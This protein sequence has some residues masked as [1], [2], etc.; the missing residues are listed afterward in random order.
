MMEPEDYLRYERHMKALGKAAGD[1]PRAFADAV[2]LQEILDMQIRAAIP[3][4]LKQGFSWG[5][6]AN[7]LGIT[8]QVAHRKYRR[9]AG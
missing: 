5:D 1:D 2:L 8:R 3:V 6:I 4:L 7:E 9:T